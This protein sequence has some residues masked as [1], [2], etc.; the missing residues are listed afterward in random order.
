MASKKA[1]ITKRLID[2]LKPHDDE[3]LFV[4]DAVLTRYGLRMKPSGSATYLVLSRGE[5]PA[6]RALF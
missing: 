6:A 4:W 5:R 1:K 2:A 3:D